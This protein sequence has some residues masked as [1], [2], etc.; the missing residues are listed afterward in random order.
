MDHDQTRIPCIAPATGALIGQLPVADSD[1]VHAAVQRSREAQV[2]WAELKVRQRAQALMRLRELLVA[3]GPDLAALLSLECGKPEMEAYMSEVFTLADLTAYFCRRAPRILRD[4]RIALHLM[5]HR[6]SFVHYRPRG[7]VGIISPWNFP[8]VIPGGDMVM[9]LLA[10]NGVVIKPSEVTPLIALRLQELCLEAGLPEGL[11]GVVPG[12]GPTGAALIE[13]GVDKIVFTGSVATGRRVALACAERL[14]PCVLELGGKAPAIVLPGANIERTARALVFGAF[15]NSGQVCVSVE[16]AY[17]HTDIHDR[18]VARVVALTERL[19]QGDPG[20]GEVDVGAV[21]HG[22]QMKT[23]LDQVTDAVQR[24]AQV[25]TGGA[26]LE[27]PGQF[28]AP[29][30]LSGVPQDAQVMQEETFG[31]LLPI[32]AVSSTQEAIDKANDSHLGLMAYVFAGSAAEGE[33]VARQLVAGTVM[34]NDVLNTYAMPETPWAGLKQSGLGRVHSDEALTDMC[35]AR[36]INLPILPALR[37]EIWWYPYR[38]STY[39]LMRRLVSLLFG[40]GIRRLVPADLDK[41]GAV[42]LPEGLAAP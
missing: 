17:V 14:I 40:R 15:C 12:Y 9:A 10:G 19:R 35:Q 33:A 11:V 25:R 28:F 6:R 30:V 37:R 1:A 20:Q 8:L 39:R 5:K 38:L 27:G 13:A 21:I 36:H 34:V 3:Q 22:P 18:L 29:T 4:K 7:V 42:R 23:A 41:Q 2:G 32:H 26:P 24:G 16:R 31:P